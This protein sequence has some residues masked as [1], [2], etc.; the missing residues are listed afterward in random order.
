MVYQRFICYFIVEC[1]FVFDGFILL[2]VAL[3]PGQSPIIDMVSL[4][5]LT[6]AICSVR[7]IAWLLRANNASMME[8]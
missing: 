5:T 6:S 4:S 3:C 1:Q 8:S 7:N 2:I